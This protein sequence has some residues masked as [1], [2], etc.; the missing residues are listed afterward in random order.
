MYLFATVYAQVVVRTDPMKQ[1][2]RHGLTEVYR[3]IHVA[4]SL[5]TF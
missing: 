5:E 4:R 2:V 1:R 3:L